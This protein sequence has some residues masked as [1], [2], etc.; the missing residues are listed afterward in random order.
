MLEYKEK[1]PSA[2]DYKICSGFITFGTIKSKKRYLEDYLEA[3]KNKS[4]PDKFKIDDK[5]IEFV[6]A[7]DPR[8]LNYRFKPESRR[9]WGLLLLYIIM[10]TAVILLGSISYG[11]RK[12]IG[13]N[14]PVACSNSKYTLNGYANHPLEERTQCE[15]AENKLFANFS[16]YFLLIKARSVVNTLG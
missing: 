2:I 10:Y 9:R 8:D 16:R 13:M 1:K 11:S 12:L 6:E 5:N 4:I 15:C 3:L 14:Q 7:P